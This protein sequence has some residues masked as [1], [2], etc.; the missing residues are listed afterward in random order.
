MHL[1]GEKKNQQF[2]VGIICRQLYKNGMSSNEEQIHGLLNY[3][4][5]GL[6]NVCCIKRNFILRFFFLKIPKILAQCSLPL[7]AAMEAS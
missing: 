5:I 6:V 4:L 1:F 2:I 3:Y 7:L